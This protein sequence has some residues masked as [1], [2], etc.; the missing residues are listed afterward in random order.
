[1]TSSTRIQGEGNYEADQ[2]FDDAQEAFAKS[3]KVDAKAREAASKAAAE[4]TSV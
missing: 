3:G 4:V 1:M 2:K